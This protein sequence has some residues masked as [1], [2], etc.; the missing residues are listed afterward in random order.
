MPLENQAAYKIV[1]MTN[2]SAYTFQIKLNV[3]YSPSYQAA[4]NLIID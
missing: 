3:G 2:F 1:L 4:I